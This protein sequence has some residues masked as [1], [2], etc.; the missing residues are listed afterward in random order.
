MASSFEELALLKGGYIGGYT[1]HS[2]DTLKRYGDERIQS[3]KVVRTPISGA[4][5]RLLNIITLGKMKRQKNRHGYNDFFH[6]YLVATVQGGKEVV[7]EKNERV[8]IT[9]S[10]SMND[11]SEVMQ[12]DMQ[13]HSFTPRMMLDA[14]F[15]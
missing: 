13:Q 2:R 6:L 11:K 1:N 8:N 5:N 10:Y 7:M 12:V 9:T 3:M 15:V 4:L 14:T